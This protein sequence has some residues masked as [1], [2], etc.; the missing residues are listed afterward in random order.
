MKKSVF[1]FAISLFVI[2]AYSQN[3]TQ[4]EYQ[5][6]KPLQNEYADFDMGKYFTPDI[7][8]NQLDFNFDFLSN[9]SRQDYSNPDWNRKYENSNFTGNISSYFSHYANTRK[10]I[11]SLIGGLTFGGDYSSRKDE[12]T[13]TNDHSTIIDHWSNSLQRISFGL[14]WSN[15]WYFSN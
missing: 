6:W 4:N 14:N 13:Y 8:R 9:N 3:S 5:E 12:Q 2:H 1:I 11:S 7:V 10:K 15:K